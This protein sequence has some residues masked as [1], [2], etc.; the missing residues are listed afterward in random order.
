MT[1]EKLKD[2]IKKEIEGLNELIKTQQERMKSEPNKKTNNYKWLSRNVGE[3]LSALDV[4]NSI[5]EKINN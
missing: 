2:F 1:I 4:Y 5:L 3:M